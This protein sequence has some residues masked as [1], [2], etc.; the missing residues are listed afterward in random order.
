MIKHFQVIS[1]ERVESVEIFE[2]MKPM[3][4]QSTSSSNNKTPTRPKGD[5]TR[6]RIV[7]AALKLLGDGRIE[8][9]S[10]QQVA[11]LVQVTR[12]LVRHHFP[13]KTDLLEAVVHQIRDDVKDQCTQA[14]EEMAVSFQGKEV[15]GFAEESLKTLIQT[16]LKFVATHQKE[17]SIWILFLKVCSQEEAYRHINQQF[18]DFV[19]EQIIEILKLGA[20]EGE[21]SAG[22]YISRARMMQT[23]LIGTAVTL[24]TELNR[25]GS[26]QLDRQGSITM[27]DMALRQCISIAKLPTI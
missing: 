12:Q 18:S 27:E 17:A 26:F 8:E 20:H 4:I 11:D 23:I 21:F 15:G 16:A 3:E 19:M 6:Q 25:S 2:K 9:F 13:L 7:N 14:L 10:Y 1:I 22:N 5:K 24:V